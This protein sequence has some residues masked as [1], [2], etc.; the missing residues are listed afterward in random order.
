MGDMLYSGECRQTFRG[1]STNISGNVVKHSR[2]KCHQVFRG[3]SPNIPGNVAK[4]SGECH[5]TFQGM[6][7]SISGNVAKHSGEHSTNILDAM[8]SQIQL[9]LACISILFQK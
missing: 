7:L 2:G 8:S 9:I 6:S 1:M 5:Q 4:H 3:M